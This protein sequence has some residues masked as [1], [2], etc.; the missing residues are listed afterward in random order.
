LLI[1]FFILFT[2]GKGKYYHPFK[3]DIAYPAK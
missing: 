3:N 2:V 1:G